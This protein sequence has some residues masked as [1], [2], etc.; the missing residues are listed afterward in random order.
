MLG[1]GHSF[2]V[3]LVTE[4]GIVAVKCP[5]GTRELPGGRCF[6]WEISYILAGDFLR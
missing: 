3:R 5:T 1:Q 4:A 6:A 2:L